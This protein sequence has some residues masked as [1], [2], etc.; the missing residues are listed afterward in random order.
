ML[1]FCSSLCLLSPRGLSQAVLGE[2]LEGGKVATGAW[3]GRSYSSLWF[4]AGVGGQQ[5]HSSTG[6]AEGP[7]MG[8]SLG[9]DLGLGDL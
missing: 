8:V 4:T 2:K 6:W 1:L 7:G 3:G 9:H 5:G